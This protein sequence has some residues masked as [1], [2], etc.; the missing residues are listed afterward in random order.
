[1][2]VGCVL[3]ERR[4][5]FRV[6]SVTRTLCLDRLGSEPAFRDLAPSRFLL[7]HKVR[8]FSAQACRCCVLLFETHSVLRQCRR[9]VLLI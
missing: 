6:H 3:F 4:Q 9:C 1:L 2:S 7:Q 8:T 5:P